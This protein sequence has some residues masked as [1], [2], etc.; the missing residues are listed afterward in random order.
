MND[1]KSTSMTRLGLSLLLRR[2]NLRARYI[3]FGRR[4]FRDD[5]TVPNAVVPHTNNAGRWNRSGLFF[6]VCFLF[7]LLIFLCLPLK[8]QQP[9][10]FIHA[11][12]GVK[13]S[14][15]PIL[16]I[17]QDILGQLNLII[18]GTGFFIN[19]S[20][21]FLTAAHVIAE[22]R[23]TTIMQPT[24]CV[25]AIYLPENGWQRD[26]ANFNIKWHAFTD[27]FVD[28]TLDI[29][30]CKTIDDVTSGIRPMTFRGELLAD[31][32]AVAFTGFPLGA[33]EPLSARGYVAAYRAA[34]ENLGP[35]ELVIDRQNWPG[36]SGSPAYDVDG[37][38]VGIVLQRGIGDG[39][40][41][42]I[43]RPT[44]RILAFLASK[45][46][47]VKTEKDAKHKHA[48]KNSHK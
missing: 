28:E 23:R 46:V 37:N 11:I 38:V 24:A 32:T 39:V 14:V 25:M 2:P 40:G 34:V 17:R 16:C 6:R 4:T 20:G 18:D 7:I 22:L 42:A 13:S 47:Q 30:A 27:C 12:E 44:S 1:V 26:A 5:T 8:A 9:D 10:P 36:S 41:M 3:N 29:A 31:G 35:T 45:N 33:V 15:V 21:Y 48:S 43:A 19:S